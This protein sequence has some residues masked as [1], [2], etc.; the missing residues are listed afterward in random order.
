MKKMEPVAAVK[1]KISSTLAALPPEGIAEL[2]RYVDH[3]ADKYHVVQPPA[4]IT[5]GGFWTNIPF[6]VEEAEI[7]A[8]RR[9][10]TIDLLDQR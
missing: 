5:L 4:N 3:L 9:H 1:E 7:R 8:L 10:V 6:D 2:S